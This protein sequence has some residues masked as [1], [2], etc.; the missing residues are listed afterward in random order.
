MERFPFSKKGNIMKRKIKFIIATIA[1]GCF[2]SSCGNTNDESKKDDEIP[3]ERPTE[4]YSDYSGDLEP[5][6][7][8][9]ADRND[10][11]MGVQYYWGKAKVITPNHAMIITSLDDYNKTLNGISYGSGSVDYINLVNLYFND[12][13]FDEVLKLGF[14]DYDYNQV[15]IYH[16][17]PGSI[18]FVKYGD[19][20]QETFT[21]IKKYAPEADIYFITS[22]DNDFDLVNGL[23]IEKVQAL[24]KTRDEVRGT[25]ETEIQG[26]TNVVT[27]HEKS[28]NTY[29]STKR[30]SI[31][32]SNI[33]FTN[34]STLGNSNKRVLHIGASVMFA[35]YSFIQSNANDYNIDCYCSSRGS[36]DP[37]FL[38]EVEFFLRQYDYDGVHFNSGSHIKGQ[39]ET[40][41]YNSVSALLDYL[42]QHESKAKIIMSN[43]TPRG[44]T[45]N[46]REFSDAESQEIIT[47]STAIIRLADERNIPFD[48]LYNFAK[49]K[50]FV[51]IDAIHYKSGGVE[52]QTL[53][54]EIANFIKRYIK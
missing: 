45:S 31:E 49:E 25:I 48:D 47:M 27:S 35:T 24:K 29:A 16:S 38:R 22:N 40:E 14:I 7:I 17:R 18:E 19:L 9:Y 1:A 20:L 8:N 13:A 2:L 15:F 12:G 30:E 41:C 23:E 54:K 53:G 5:M 34:P 46:L 37:A 52:Y 36:N 44:T 4:L 3:Q 43:S 51:R 11:S 33:Y 6:H 50:N 39:S 28:T 42:G 32:W 10:T 21:K 26:C